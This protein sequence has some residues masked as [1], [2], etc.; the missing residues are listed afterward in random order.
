MPLLA[1]G[2]NDAILNWQGTSDPRASTPT[3]MAPSWFPTGHPSPRTRNTASSPVSLSGLFNGWLLPHFELG[4]PNPPGSSAGEQWQR[5]FLTTT[6]RRWDRT[7]EDIIA[8]NLLAF[9]VRGFD[10]NAPVFL[11]SGRDG[12]PGVENVDDDGY[13]TTD[14]ETFLV[15]GEPSSELGTPGSDD[16]L[17]NVSDLAMYELMNSNVLNPAVAGTYGY[18][19][20]SLA[21]RGAFVDLLY[22]YLAGS[23]L[24]ERTM[25]ARSTT[26]LIIPITPPVIAPAV[27]PAVVPRV[28][29]NYGSALQPAQNFMSSDLSAFEIDPAA[30]SPLKKSGKL[31]HFGAGGAICYL[32][33][34]YDTWT[35]GYES[36]GFDQSQ[37]TNGSV[38][39]ATP[40]GTT[41]VLNNV[42]VL[43]KTPR[44]LDPGGAG[45]QLYQIDT[46]RLLPTSSE[47]SPPIAKDLPAISV[48]VRVADP[49]TE[50]MT[51]FTIIESLE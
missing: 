15:F 40:A 24:R 32:Q 14:D 33:P 35:D 10:R 20:Q 28:Q 47:T 3:A 42:A 46:G 26:P 45:L 8:T 41:W 12:Q 7:G 5:G 27:T 38:N 50:G 37:S 30:L 17:V 44:L 2:W 13:G 43:S 18:H 4:D 29:F 9:D 25:Q 19:L 36:D 22:P 39:S 21:T 34:T 1:L 11:T 6:D 51:Q 16:E 49:L 48:T 31:V 23:P